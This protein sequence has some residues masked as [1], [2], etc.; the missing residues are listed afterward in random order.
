MLVLGGLRGKKAAGPVAAYR[1]HGANLLGAGSPRTVA[2]AIGQCD[3][4]LRH[5][6]A[7]SAHPLLAGRAKD[8]EKVL[9]KLRGTRAQE[10][11]AYLGMPCD[12]AGAW[13]E[14]IGRIAEN[15]GAVPLPETVSP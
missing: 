7:F 2:A 6:R 12:D 8:T 10:L 11:T 15:L 14:G 4:M 3:A 5:Y 9:A 13:F 1:L